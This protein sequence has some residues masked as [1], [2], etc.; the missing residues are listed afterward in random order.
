MLIDLL[1]TYN[2][3]LRLRRLNR[4]TNRPPFDR[5]PDFRLAD[6]YLATEDLIENSIIPG[7]RFRPVDLFLRT[8]DDELDTDCFMPG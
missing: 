6:L 3:E 4:Q 8:G 7:Y 2:D 1:L 5:R